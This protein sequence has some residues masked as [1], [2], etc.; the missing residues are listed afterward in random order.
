ME[1]FYLS[2]KAQ[3]KWPLLCE[4]FSFSQAELISPHSGL[5]RALYRLLMIQQTCMRASDGHTRGAADTEMEQALSL[6]QRCSTR[7]D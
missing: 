4:V 1:N 5:H 6:L 3:H 2:F 7:S